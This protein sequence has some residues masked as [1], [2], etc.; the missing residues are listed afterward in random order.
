MEAWLLKHSASIY[1]GAMVAGF[2]AIAVWETLQPR[3]ALVVSTA[4][5][6]LVHGGF[7]VLGR[8][9]IW[10]AFPVSAVGLS[11]ALA[12]SRY[13][14]LNRSVLPFSVR[15]VL[16]FL[17]LDLVLY[18]QH[19]LLHKVPLLWRLHRV[20]HSDRE[21]DLTTGIRFHPLESL[22]LQG[23]ILLVI[24]LTAPPV[25]AVICFELVNVVQTFF[26]HANLRLPER[27][28]RAMRLVQVTPELHRV[29]HS[30]EPS[31]HNTNFGAV[32][33]FWDRLF[34]TLRNESH[35][36]DAQFEFGLKDVS[37]AQSVRVG[38]LLALPFRSET[39]P[40]ADSAVPQAVRQTA[41]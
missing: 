30:L 9:A 33:T 37:A 40:P 41:P 2:L 13:G 19:Y 5:R 12:G 11:I 10:L 4:K 23:V 27:V 18:G 16:T 25:S 24:A 28:E 26:A 1:Q 8:A 15:F 29:H 31:D 32:F 14:L 21:Y 36:G 7:V 34:G 22:Y 39:R 35:L 17:L 6:W 3:R 20:H 38:N